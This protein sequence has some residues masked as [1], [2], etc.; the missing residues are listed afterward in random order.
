M[1]SLRRSASPPATGRFAGLENFRARLLIICNAL[2]YIQLFLDKKRLEVLRLDMK[3][4]SG[5]LCS[6]I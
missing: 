1:Q 3:C 2:K 6:R 4:P 5:I